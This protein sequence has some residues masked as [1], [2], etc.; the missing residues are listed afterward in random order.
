MRIV[1]AAAVSGCL[2]YYPAS[3]EERRE[4]GAHEHGHGSLN[5]AIEGN[6]VAM[7][8]EVP[9]HDIVGF[10]HAAKT[11]EQKAAVTKAKSQLSAPLKLFRFPAAAGCAVRE[12]KVELEGEEHDHEHA[13]EA[14]HK[15]DDHDDD[16]QHSEFHAEYSLECGTI[17]N[18]TTIEFRYFSLFKGAEELEVSVISPKGQSKFEVERENPRLE[19]SG[20]M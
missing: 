14:S 16:H 11:E 10:E 19:L 7:E 2:L 5:I 6:R 18:V 15:H 20:L 8:L 9:G 1:M 17:A 4:V 13:D 3:A 12:A